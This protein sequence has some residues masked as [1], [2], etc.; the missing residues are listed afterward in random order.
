[1]ENLANFRRRFLGKLQNL[2]VQVLELAQEMKLLK[3]DRVCLD[4]TKIHANASKHQALSYGHIEQL[5]TQLKAEVQELLALAEQADQTNI[6][7]GVDL[8][9]EISRREDRLVV[10]R[11]A[12]A[13]ITARAQARHEKEQ[14][15]YAE[16]M[17]RRA[18][19]EA[20]GQKPRSEVLKAP[21]ATPKAQ[22]RVNLTDPE[23]RLMPVSG[24]SFEQAYNAQPLCDQTMLVVATGVNQATNDKEQGLPMLE[25]LQAQG[26]TTGSVHA[27]IADTDYCSE[28]N[29]DA[30]EALGITL[31]IAVAREDH[32]PDWRQ[33]HGEPEA[34]GDDATRMQAMIHCL[35]TQVGRS[36]YRM[37]KQTVE[38]VFGIIK[39]VTGFR[40][41]SLRGLTQVQGEWSLIAF[42]EEVEKIVGIIGVGLDSAK[43]GNPPAKFQEPFTVIK[44]PGFYWSAHA[45]EEGPAAYIEESL[46]VL[47]AERIDHGTRGPWSHLCRLTRGHGRDGSAPWPSR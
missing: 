3:V 38:P 14:A 9:E 23:S 13:K 17:A 46:D 36:V 18:V 37:R 24:G 41:F 35:K 1:M 30:C 12:K 10:M 42:L 16:K 25:T 8:P 40:Q 11:D 4:G 27:L 20:A 43:L 31:I 44:T 7:D 15:V 19:Q 28:K 33:Q 39:S 45:G 21:D 47:Q 6:P 32:H 22:D 5:E 26:A 2:F 34:L 29:V